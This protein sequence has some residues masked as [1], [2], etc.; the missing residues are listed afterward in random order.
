MAAAVDF[1]IAMLVIAEGVV[2][3]DFA[4]AGEHQAFGSLGLADVSSLNPR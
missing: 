4:V 1:H 2:A 3:F